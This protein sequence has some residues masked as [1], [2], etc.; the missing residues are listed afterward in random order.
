MLDSMF[1]KA[2]YL[3]KIGSWKESWAAYEEILC[4][5]KAG[6]SKKIDATMEK[7]KIA[8]FT[9]V[10]ATN[11]L[12]PIALSV[13]CCNLSLTFVSIPSPSPISV[14]VSLPPRRGSL[15]DTAQLKECV[16]E[17]KRLNETGGDWDR[18]NRLKVS[19]VAVTVTVTFTVTFCVETVAVLR[20]LISA[21]SR[22][23]SLPHLRRSTKPTTCSLCAT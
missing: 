7:A 17:A 22:S 14:S 18:R 9:M 16:A 8:L 12:L 3:A 1:A 10:S 2:R 5:E 15:Q 23:L 11:N 19:R 4:K 20:D 6:T 21:L 13:R